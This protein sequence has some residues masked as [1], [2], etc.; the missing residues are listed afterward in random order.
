MFKAKFPQFKDYFEG[1][2]FLIFWLGDFI[3]FLFL[4]EWQ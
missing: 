2:F 3:C 1:K 4:K